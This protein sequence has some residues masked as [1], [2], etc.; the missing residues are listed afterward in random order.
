MPFEE[1]AEFEIAVSWNGSPTAYRFPKA[2]RLQADKLKVARFSSKVSS[3]G[4]GADEVTT[5]LFKYVLE[6][7]LSG[8]GT[9]EPLAIEFVSWPD[10]VAGELLT[11]RV[12]ITIAVPVPQIATTEGEGSLL[13][14]GM[15]VL[16][17]IG[18]AV[19]VVLFLRKR[20][21][22]EAVKTPGQMFL[23][24][25]TVLRTGSSDLK[26]FQTGLYKNLLSFLEAK[27]GIAVSGRSTGMIVADLEKTDLSLHAR[28]KIAG[29]LTRAEKEKYSPSVMLPG[30]SLRL[31]SEVRE[32]FEKM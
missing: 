27:Y 30:E 25:L 1:T 10:S 9:I 3:T 28:E 13:L 29:W 26:D 14:W 11:D 21:P 4:I 6:P 2:L 20:E 12:T 7:T 15:I 18:G 16:V 23:D 22:G 5:K 24:E 17:V 32:L 31:E 8:Q 19:G